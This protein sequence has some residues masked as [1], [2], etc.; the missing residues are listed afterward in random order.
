MYCNLPPATRRR[1]GTV[2]VWV[3]VCSSVIVGIVALGLDGGRMMEERRRVQTAADA[4]AL[5]AGYD[6]YFQYQQNQGKDPDHTARSAALASARTNGYA[7]DGVSSTV[8]VNIPPASGTFA[9]QA[10]YAEVIVQSKLRATFSALFTQGPL[11]VQARAVVHGAPRKIGLQL[12]GSGAN[13]LVA[14]GSA[15][16]QLTGVPVTVNS[17]DVS[18]YVVSGGAS[19]SAPTHYLAGSGVP[20]GGVTGTVY[21]SLPPTPDPFVTLAAPSASAYPVRA[22][23]QTSIGGS[24]NVSLQ[25]G[26]YTGGISIGGGST[27]TLVS[28][29]YILQGGG[30]QLSG[31]AQVTGTGVLIYNTGPSGGPISI[32]GS[33]SLTLSPPTSGT[34]QGIG[35]FQDPSLTQAVQVSGSGT[36]TSGLIYAPAAALQ[37]GGSAVGSV[38]GGGYV[39]ATLQA[40]GSASVSVNPGSNLPRVPNV[41]LVE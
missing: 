26:V 34:Y 30:L 1:P 31:D 22:T 38:V 40:T 19:V 3:V 4:A 32:S 9:G 17:T 7:N 33:A 36:L 8:T 37:L 6:L 18:S 23:S 41:T 28:G 11:A 12:L 14:S 5:A 35:I 27:V 15:R 16:V 2:T 13:V 21:T 39:A 20:S 10:E 24:S 25:P 29:V